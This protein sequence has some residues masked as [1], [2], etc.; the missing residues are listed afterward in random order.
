VERIPDMQANPMGQEHDRNSP[1]IDAGNGFEKRSVI[2]KQRKTFIQKLVCADIGRSFSA[3]FK[4][5]NQF[6]ALEHP[7]NRRKRGKKAA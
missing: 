3:R 2:A 6:L 7:V 4:G 1:D 5:L